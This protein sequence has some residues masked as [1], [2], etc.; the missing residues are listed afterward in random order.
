ML[1]LHSSLPGNEN[2]F[3]GLYSPASSP[4]VPEDGGRGGRGLL[5][6]PLPLFAQ[7]ADGRK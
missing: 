2:S 5:L 6:G 1:F 7:K 4:K 3:H